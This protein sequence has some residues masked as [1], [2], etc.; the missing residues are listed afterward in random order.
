MGARA[1]S[2]L[3]VGMVIVAST[4]EA[5]ETALIRIEHF[6]PTSVEVRLGGRVIGQTPVAITVST[7]VQRFTVGTFEVCVYVGAS[8]GTIIG[9]AGAVQKLERLLPCADV[10]SEVVLTGVP[11]DLEIAAT[12]GTVSRGAQGTVVRIPFPG[13]VRLAYAGG[14]FAPFAL[15]LD[16][17]PRERVFARIN[18][19]PPW[20]ALISDTLLTPIPRPPGERPTLPVAVPPRDP[21][22][23]L[24]NSELR[25]QIAESGREPRAA[26]LTMAWLGGIALVA[27]AIILP[28]SSD[29]AGPARDAARKKGWAVGGIGG[30]S[31]L[32][33]LGLISVAN[34]RA[35]RASCGGGGGALNQC[36]EGLRS[37]IAAL[38]TE[39]DNYPASLQHWKAGRDSLEMSH[40]LALASYSERHSAWVIADQSAREKNRVAVMNAAENRSRLDAWLSR[41]T[42]AQ[43]IEVL[44]R[45]P[46]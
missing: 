38:R 2:A 39:L 26:G 4:V 16:V 45:R 19:G 37:T 20:P 46:R 18:P 24:M 28:D 22:P 30:A 13:V 8:G 43:T 10:W 35:Q 27:G 6:S 44:S 15:T 7:G 14:R 41:A 12:P 42:A 40:R 9:A 21:A 17:G 1:L 36:V 29:P 32:A 3:V 25:L 34:N 31:L 23:E 5:Q 33:G 11:S